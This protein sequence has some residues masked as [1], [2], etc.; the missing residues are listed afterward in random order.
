ME[1]QSETVLKSFQT[2]FLDKNQNIIIPLL[3]R[4]YVQGGRLDVIDPFLNKLID[5]ISKEQTQ[6]NLEYIY[7]YNTENG[8]VVSA[9]NTDQ[10]I[11]FV[12]TNSTTSFLRKNRPAY[13]P[14]K[15]KHF[16]L[17]GRPANSKYIMKVSR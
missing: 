14:E 9:S 8:F 13:I 5:A 15:A 12:Y 11:F 2:E 6:I 10:K 4:D 3:Q 7:G 16:D 1:T 17:L